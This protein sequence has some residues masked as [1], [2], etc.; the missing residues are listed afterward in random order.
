MKRNHRPILHLTAFKLL[1]HPPSYISVPARIEKVAGGVAALLHGNKARV[2]TGRVGTIVPDLHASVKREFRGR[3][4]EGRKSSY[5]IIINGIIP[6][7]GVT[8]YVFADGRKGEER[9]GRRR[10]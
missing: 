1:R 2:E 10:V 5:E 7:T 9:K 6:H 8:R 3:N 4:E